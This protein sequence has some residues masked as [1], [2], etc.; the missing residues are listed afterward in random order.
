MRVAGSLVGAG[1][2][3]VHVSQTSVFTCGTIAFHVTTEYRLLQFTHEACWRLSPITVWFLEL[4][5]AR[6]TGYMSMSRQGGEPQL[7]WFALRKGGEGVQ[8]YSVA[9]GGAP[10][11]GTE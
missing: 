9:Q 8:P 1:T 6:L 2:P 7:N 5:G 10:R 4:A 11:H 3:C